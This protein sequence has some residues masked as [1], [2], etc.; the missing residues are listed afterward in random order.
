VV[1]VQSIVPPKYM[2]E[3]IGKRKAFSVIEGK[4]MAVHLQ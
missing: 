2:E 4:E 1:R 3:F